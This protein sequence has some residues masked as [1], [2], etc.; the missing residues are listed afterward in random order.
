MA[1][2]SG[3]AKLDGYSHPSSSHGSSN[4]EKRKDPD[5]GKFATKLNMAKNELS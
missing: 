1:T 5:M 2:W 4:P 3:G